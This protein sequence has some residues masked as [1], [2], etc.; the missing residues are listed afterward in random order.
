MLFISRLNS[1]TFEPQSSGNNFTFLMVLI[2]CLLVLAFLIVSFIL[3]KVFVGKFYSAVFYEASTVRSIRIDKK[4]NE[5]RFFN[6]SALKKAK[7]IPLSKFYASFP[8]YEQEKVQNYVNDIFAGKDVAPFLRV[9]VTFHKQ[10]VEAPSFL[11]ITHID[12]EKEIIHL[13][14]HLLHFDKKDVGKNKRFSSLQEFSEDFRN[15]NLTT[16]ATYCFLLKLK[17]AS[18]TMDI[19]PSRDIYLKFKEVISREVKGNERLIQLSDNEII[20]SDL[21]SNDNA[22]EIGFALKAQNRILKVL[23]NGLKKKNYNFDVRVG[24]VNNQDLINDPQMIINEARHMSQVAFETNQSLIFYKKGEVDYSERQLATYKNEV[25]RIIYNNKITYL[26]R[27]IYSTSRKRV[28]AYL[29]K[30]TPV[31]TSFQN[32]DEL[33]TYAVRA[34][35]DKSLFAAIGKNA[36]SRFLSERVNKTTSLYFPLAFHELDY[37][38]TFFTYIKNAKEASLFF[39]IK[40]DDLFF[41]LKEYDTETLISKFKQIHAAGFKLCLNLNGDSLKLDPSLYKSFDSFLVDFPEGS[42]SSS[43]LDT[44][45]RSRLHALVERLLKYKKPIIANNLPTWNALELVIG[46]GLEYFSSDAFAPFHPMLKPINEKILAK[47]KTFME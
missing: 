38:L 45:I 20:V 3:L 46:S 36:L 34:K 6:L 5:A 16:G 39:L 9:D 26:F 19:K 31:N 33:K 13:E 44:E 37:V 41:H 47:L 21:E 2:A 30:P 8:L 25:E 12:L 15:S 4:K 27:P 42:H 24:I 35:D 43:S 29:L 28:I 22:K 1:V 10:K 23:N 11:K 7:T 17:K 14:S 18:G 40:E 32:I